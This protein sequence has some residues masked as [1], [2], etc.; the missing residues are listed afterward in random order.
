MVLL[1]KKRKVVKKGE[2]WVCMG[3]SVDGRGVEKKMGKR[4]EGCVW[5][6]GKEWGR[7]KRGK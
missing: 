3:M 5:S 4:I 2:G 6:E 7:G 1:L